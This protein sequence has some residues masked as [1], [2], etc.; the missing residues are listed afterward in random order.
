MPTQEKK[1]GLIM[2]LEEV[3]LIHRREVLCHSKKH[4]CSGVALVTKKGAM[5]RVKQASLEAQVQTLYNHLDLN[6]DLAAWLKILPILS[7]QSTRLTSMCFLEF[8]WRE[9]SNKSGNTRKTYMISQ[10]KQTKA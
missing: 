9:S 3:L 4:R 10:R 8:V 2:T 7:S 6:L 1:V 5:V